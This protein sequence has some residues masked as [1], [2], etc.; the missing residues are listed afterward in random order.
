VLQPF[1]FDQRQRSHSIYRPDLFDISYLEV[2]GMLT[3]VDVSIFQVKAEV[4]SES[5]KCDSAFY[6]HYQTG[7]PILKPDLKFWLFL[8]TG[9]D[10]SGNKKKPDKI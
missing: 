2:C 4:Y 8:K 3:G 10:F 5:E 9:F 1:V 7:L 6:A